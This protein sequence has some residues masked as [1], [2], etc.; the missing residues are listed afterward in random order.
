[1]KIFTKIVGFA[2]KY[3]DRCDRVAFRKNEISRLS[4]YV[5]GF[6]N[7]KHVCVAFARGAV[8]LEVG[9]GVPLLRLLLGLAFGSARRRGLLSV[10]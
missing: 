1:M 6:R 10:R 4:R 8:K 7:D 3:G 2:D 5:F 9:H